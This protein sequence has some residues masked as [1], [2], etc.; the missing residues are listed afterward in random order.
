LGTLDRPDSGS[1][2]FNAE[3]LFD[4]PDVRL[5]KFRNE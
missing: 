5:A 3:N 2:Q 1:L 4:Y